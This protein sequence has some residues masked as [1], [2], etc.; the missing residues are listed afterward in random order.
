MVLENCPENC[1]MMTKTKFTH[2]H[3]KQKHLCIGLPPSLPSNLEGGV[4]VAG[5]RKKRRRSFFIQKKKHS[6]TSVENNPSGSPQGSIEGEEDEDQDEADDD[7][8]SED[9]GSEQQ[10]ESMEDAEVRP[11]PGL[12]QGVSL[13]RPAPTGDQQLRTVPTFLLSGNE[14]FMLLKPS[15]QKEMR[16]Q[17][18]TNPLEWSVAEVVRFIRT[19]D[20]A[21][22]SRL[23][24]DQEIDG[25]ALLLLTLPTVQEC[26]ELKLGPAIKLCHHIERLKVAFYQ[27][28]AH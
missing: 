11:S 21:P 24:R 13:P 17:L 8:G 3:G 23:F 20:C 4:K 18:E 19:T 1:S 10:E 6:A 12:E 2:F 25:Q 22:L 27:H 28:F 9:S 16:L 7:S 14:K 26:M 5:K 15:S